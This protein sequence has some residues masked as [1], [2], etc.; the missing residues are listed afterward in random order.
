[1][2]SKLLKCSRGAVTACCSKLKKTKFIKSESDKEH[3]NK[4]W[5]WVD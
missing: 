2:L 1:M 4:L 5:Y 3:V